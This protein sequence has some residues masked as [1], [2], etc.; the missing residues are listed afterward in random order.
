MGRTKKVSVAGKFGPRYGFTLRRRLAE[1]ESRVRRRYECP[2]CG[3]IKLRRVNTSIWQC[4]RCGVKFAGKAYG[5]GT[6]AGTG[7][8]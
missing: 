7:G 3:A 8:L 5:P 6:R 4:R 2:S 1:V